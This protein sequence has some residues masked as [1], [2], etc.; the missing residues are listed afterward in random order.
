[1]KKSKNDIE[2]RALQ[3]FEQALEY[4]KDQRT[5]FLESKWGGDEK[6]RNRVEALLK[7]DS[8][9]TSAIQT[10]QAIHDN[11]EKDLTNIE[12]GSYRIKS[13]IGVGGMGAVYEA[14]RKTGDFIHTVAIKVIKP[15]VLSEPIIKRF[16]R[17][18]QTLADFSHPNIARLFDGGTTE[19][20]EPYIIMEK[21]D[22]LSITEFVETNQ[23]GKSERL[24]LFVQSCNAISYAH[25]N[26]IV[27]RDITPNNVLVTRDG[28]VKLIDF[29]IAKTL[30]E[31]LVLESSQNALPSLS[32][33]PGFAA[34]ERSKG[35]AANTL[36]D[37][38]S[39][40]KLLQ[41]LLGDKHT[42]SDL[43]AIVE[44]STQQDPQNRY[45]SV[46][47]LIGDI[48]KYIT[49]FPVAAVSSRPGYKISKFIKRHRLGSIASSLAIMG[50]IAAFSITTF[51]YKRAEAARLEADKRFNDVRTLADTLMTDIHD[52][53]YRIPGSTQATKKII[54]ASQIYLDDLAKANDAP[55][56]IKRDIAIGYRKLG[57]AVAGSKYGNISDPEAADLY[58]ESSEQ[59]LAG[60]DETAPPDTETL[61]AL[62]LLYYN[63][64]EVNI[65]P[66]RLFNLAEE[67][68]ET[69]IRYLERGIELDPSHL[70][71]QRAYLYSYC[72]RD[73][74]WT[75]KGDIERAQNLLK[76]CIEKAGEFYAEFPQDDP[77]SFR[78]MRLKASSGR[79][80]ANSFSIQQDYAKAI[81]ALDIAIADT[82]IAATHTDAQT[83]GFLMRDRTIGHWRR[84]Y[85]HSYLENY[86]AALSDYKK[87]LE[88]TNMRLEID[89]NDKDAT[90]FYYV[91]I[92]ERAAP[93]QAL[94]RHKD[95]EDGLLQTLKWYEKRFEE[96]SNAP[97][98]LANLFVH[99]AMLGDFYKKVPNITKACASLSEAKNYYEIMQRN[100]TATA[101]DDIN[102]KEVIKLADGC[103][104]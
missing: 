18:R 58:F 61:F 41:S 72:Y 63:M 104:L 101:L 21:I 15:G 86:E 77:E 84:A 57:R 42:T 99:H 96:K 90:W 38:Y 29:G 78:I 52:E 34:P 26:L 103:D 67:Q 49:G 4:P 82:E 53:I 14:E 46:D 37:I 70:S 11:V 88:F 97:D 51:Q 19:D 40:G 12:I 85:A 32:F 93:L 2:F 100:K 91:I 75:V 66:R 79:N 9:R 45:A 68:L 92:A 20:G 89:P 16:E 95:A 56:D 3:L 33:T 6:L 76:D 13:Q 27:H 81:E 39:L 71:M 60:L 69:S 54:E 8:N 62:G 22:G 98:R 43:K 80:L 28:D 87:A 48:Q 59:I 64:A 5:A 55:I 50:L 35:A 74:I 83:D 102:Y 31:A 44:K 47:T 23:A 30:D 24:R 73:E 65:Q 10:G 36:S 25:Q 1:M 7:R 17:E 94:D